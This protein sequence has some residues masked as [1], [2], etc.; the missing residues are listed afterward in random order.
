MNLV[1]SLP[2]DFF[3]HL[4]FPLTQTGVTDTASKISHGREKKS[5]NHFAFALQC[6]KAHQKIYTFWPL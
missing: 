5:A 3:P 2:K 6:Q 1:Y 4:I